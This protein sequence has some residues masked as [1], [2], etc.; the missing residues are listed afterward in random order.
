[1]SPH[2]PSE[3]HKPAPAVG[4]SSTTMRPRRLTIPV[5]GVLL[6]AA[7]IFAAAAQP[8][9]PV[10]TAPVYVPDYSHAGAPLPNGVIEW[11]AESKTV[12]ATNGQDVAKF[13]FSFTNISPG[14]IA[15]LSG[16]GSCGCTTVELPPTP[17][18]IPAGGTGELGA[19][20]NL[21]GKVGMIFKYAI[22]STDKGTKNL[23]LRV[24]ILPAPPPAAMSDEARAR[25]VAAAKIDRQAVFKGDC[26]NC[27][28]QNVAG[29]FGPKSVPSVM[30]PI[31]APPW[32]PTCTI[33]KSQRAR[34]SGALG[35]R[36]ANP[37]RS[38]PP[39][40]LRKAVR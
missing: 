2:L 7:G 24:N 3:I 23:M 30:R 38:C 20:I 36:L 37:A 31:P 22:I 34:N 32:C 33:S 40:P 14:T 18:I 21:A 11:D 35:S 16:R 5:S 13:D 29:K 19:S 4:F 1:M 6:F 39:L 28:A 25:G 12:D 10:T 8:S 17:W 9:N 26:V 15:I 27:H